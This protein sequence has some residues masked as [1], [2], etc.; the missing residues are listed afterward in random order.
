MKD[1]VLPLVIAV[2]GLAATGLGAVLGARATKFGAEKSAEAVRRQVQDQ[3]AI[4]HGHW[5]R[6]QRFTTY[7]S[8]LEAWD[9]CLR[10][11]Q[12]SAADEAQDSTGLE[13]L[14][15]AA[16]RMA[17]R[18]RRIAILGPPEVTH[19]AESLAETM[20]DDVKVA[21]RFIEV[22]RTAI[23][24]VD[25]HPIPTEAV[26]EATD[27][28]RHRSQQIVELVNDHRSQG[29]DLRELD[30]HP[31]LRAAL[32]NMEQYRQRS[33]EAREAL[34]ANLERLSAAAS[35]AFSMADVLTRNREAREL[36]REQ[37]TSAAREALSK[38]PTPELR[39]DPG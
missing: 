29:R 8:F 7:E 4:E 16:D 5:L 2:I 25:G 27:E 36:S 28:Y 18:A 38:T 20:Q 37:F 32:E 14:R 15:L 1:F 33:G 9:E 22:T 19:A 26:S 12:A 11:T 17:E 34:S 13:D 23:A 10:I 31:L 35:E 30:G 6:Q 21:V 24:A 39:A 3:G